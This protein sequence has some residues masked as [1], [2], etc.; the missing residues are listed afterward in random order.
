MPAPS[1]LSLF[2]QPQDLLALTPEDL[3][4]VIVEAVPPLIQN[5]MFT[6]DSLL[7]PLY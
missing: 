6:I 5:G 3:G 1:L 7:N 2:P 4:G